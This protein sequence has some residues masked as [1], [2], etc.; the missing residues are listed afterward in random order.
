MTL[1][2]RER[3]LLQALLGARGR[4]L[5]ADELADRVYGWT[6]SVESNALA[7]HIHSLRRKFG[8]GLIETVRGQGYRL[9]APP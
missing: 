9:G 6:E 4:V 3:A 2:R 7:V 8:D 1:P 5:T